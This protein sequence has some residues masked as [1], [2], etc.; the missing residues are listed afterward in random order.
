[1]GSIA[2]IGGAVISHAQAA[3]ATVSQNMAN[4]LTPGYRA[5]R[6]FAR[7]LVPEQ[8]EATDPV[9]TVPDATMT[10][11]APGK[12][13]NTGNPLDLAIQGDGF[14]ML[15][16]GDKTYYSRSGQFART[17]DG[18]LAT[19][20]G[21]ILQG[22]SGDV[23]TTGSGLQVTGDGVILQDGTPVARL[24][25]KRFVDPSH[26]TPIGGSSFEAD[27]AAAED[28]VNPA[29]RQ[30][31]LESANVSSGTEMVELM[32]AMRRAESGQRIVQLYDELMGKAITGLDFTR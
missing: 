5:Q 16:A 31:M 29:V 32:A 23:G 20:E 9:A 30:G 15:R 13:I 6:N 28:V 21:W 4:S 11:F 2:E 8:L 17:A 7:E 3:A 25:I 1:M 12:M 26:L 22:S 24:A 19:P 10:D 27:E 14:F 18:L